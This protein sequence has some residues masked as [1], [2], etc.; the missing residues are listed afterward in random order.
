[1]K[2]LGDKNNVWSIKS[3]DG[4]VT[5]TVDKF[6]SGTSMKKVQGPYAGTSETDIPSCGQMGMPIFTSVDGTG[7]SGCQDVTMNPGRTAYTRTPFPAHIFP[8]LQRVNPTA[9]LATVNASTSRLGDKCNIV[10][11]D[12]RHSIR[13][14]WAQADATT[15]ENVHVINNQR[16]WLHEVVWWIPDITTVINHGLLS[17]VAQSDTVA[18]AQ[19]QLRLQ[20][21][22]SKRMYNAYFCNHPVV[23]D[24]AA[25][26]PT[27]LL[28]VVDIT[29]GPLTT[30]FDS[31]NEP[32]Y[33]A[34]AALQ[35]TDDN[36]LPRSRD[37][38]EFMAAGVVER[39]KDAKP[40]W[41]KKRKFRRPRAR[42]QGI[43]VHDGL[44]A[45]AMV[46]TERFQTV[47]AGRFFE[48]NKNMQ[49]EKTVE[50]DDPSSTV[51]EVCPRGCYYYCQYWYYQLN[52]PTATDS[53]A[54]QIGKPTLELSHTQ[55]VDK[56]MKLVF[57]NL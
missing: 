8:L 4:V 3:C 52:S 29:T 51:R 55:R 34:G 28:D 6:T 1:M 26:S 47:S 49:W 45:T 36:L 11:F 2:K 25:A 10:S 31:W 56:T 54:S 37:T 39:R 50:D 17:T 38:K 32:Q 24:G 43:A 12:N 40:V 19:V 42:I 30:A 23:D 13:I 48:I 27:S 44:S 7:I 46:D 18:E 53:T 15:G 14:T 33:V 35:I 57:Q 20:R 41:S 5:S 9:V 21:T 16:L 22:W